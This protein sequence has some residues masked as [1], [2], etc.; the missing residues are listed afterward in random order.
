MHSIK[1]IIFDYGGTLDTNGTHWFHIF[2]QVYSELLPHITEEQLR[3]AYIYAERYLATHRTIAPCDDFLAML[4]KKVA[5]Q[6]SLLMS[7]A[8]EN[9]SPD[10][11]SRVAEACDIHVR[12]CMK[13]TRKLLDTLSAHYPLVLVSNFYG[14]IHAVLRSYGI[15]G[16]FCEVIESAVV[17]IRKP[18]PRIFALGVEALGFKSEDILVVGDS[19]SKDIVP[20]HSIGCHTLWLKGLGWSTDNEAT[21][22]PAADAIIGNIAELPSAIDL[23]E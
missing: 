23:C 6:M 13:Q 14:N 3:E 10:A 19:Y 1:G 20:A 22:Y 9:K 4:R 16:Y 5:L 21:D 17:G 7:S 11:I 18:D 12:S 15:D 8:N 2:R